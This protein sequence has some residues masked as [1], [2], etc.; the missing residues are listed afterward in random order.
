MTL[1]PDL[2]LVAGLVPDHSRVLDLGC[3]SG[4]LLAHLRQ[5]HSCEVT[6][7]EIDGAQQVAAVRAGV[8]VLSIDIDTQLNVLSDRSFDVVVLSRTIQTIY[9]PETV[10]QHMGRIADKL[11]VSVP[12]FGWWRHRLRLLTGHMP[13]S[14]ELPYAWYNTPNIRHTTLVDLEQLFDQLDLEVVKRICFTQSG[15]RLRLSDRFANIT[16]GA[17]IYVLQPGRLG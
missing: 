1:R 10:L 17:A 3:G 6:G 8:T 16:A 11:V 4:A 14:K 9:S 5:A 7:V 2:E 15:Q 13:M 12:N